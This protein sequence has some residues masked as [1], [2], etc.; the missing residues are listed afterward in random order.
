MHIQAGRNLHLQRWRLEKPHPWSGWLK[1]MT[2]G[3]R[4]RLNWEQLKKEDGQGGRKD[5]SQRVSFGGQEWVETKDRSGTEAR[6]AGLVVERGGHYGWLPFTMVEKTAQF[7]FSYWVKLAHVEEQDAGHWLLVET[8]E[9]SLKASSWAIGGK[10]QHH[11]A[12]SSGVSEGDRWKKLHGSLWALELS[13]TARI[14][15]C[16][17]PAQR[18]A[19]R[20]FGRIFPCRTTWL[21][22]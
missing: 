20:H 18:A 1:S 14:A 2:S 3:R 5:C 4:K 19:G 7:L 10:R 6:E 15:S 13:I 12:E 16:T 17:F 22:T 21:D 11:S 9:T 8:S